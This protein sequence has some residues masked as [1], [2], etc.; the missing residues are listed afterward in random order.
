MTDGI[1]VFSDGPYHYRKEFIALIKIACPDNTDLKVLVGNTLSATTLGDM[2]I[3]FVE[4]QLLI[5]KRKL[6]TDIQLL[7]L[8]TQGRYG[9]VSLEL[10]R[11]IAL[12]T[13]LQMFAL[14][15]AYGP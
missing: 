5:E 9:A 7:E 3:Y 1:C 4:N 15:T 6:P 10:K 14:G 12:N 13:A 2:N 8:Q 11:R